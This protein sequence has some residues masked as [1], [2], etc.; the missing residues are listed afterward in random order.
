MRGPLPGLGAVPQ[1]PRA[2]AFFTQSGEVVQGLG[3]PWGGDRMERARAS[4]SLG[5]QMVTEALGA[6]EG[7]GGGV[8]THNHT[9]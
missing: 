1:A 2:A 8:Q 7:L 6:Q 5:H 3:R 9:V 4:A